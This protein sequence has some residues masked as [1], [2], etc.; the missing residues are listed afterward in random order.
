[1][2][3]NAVNECRILT[4]LLSISIGTASQ[5][6]RSA[7]IYSASA[8]LALRSA[9]LAKADL[10]VRRLV[11]H[12]PV[13]CPEESSF[14]FIQQRQVLSY[15]LELSSSGYSQAIIRSEGFTLMLPPLSL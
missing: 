1:M 12:V 13:F 15:W 5:N 14:I 4:L 11:R 3:N 9:V 8:L 7:S 10:Y 2:T 6:P